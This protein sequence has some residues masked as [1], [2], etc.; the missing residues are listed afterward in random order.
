MGR[1]GHIHLQKGLYL[2]VGSARRGLD[3]RIK[4][5]L[6]H[7]KKTH[8]HID[9]ILN[10]ARPQKIDAWIHDEAQ[11]CKTAREIM[12]KSDIN[13]I[14]KGIGSSDCKCPTHFFC[15]RGQISEI[16]DYLIERGYKRWGEI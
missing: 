9:Y 4:R 5:H 2:Y 12:H 3:K 6:V 1:F 15:F 16:Y 8:W 14:R 13:I 7:Q 10:T 11:E